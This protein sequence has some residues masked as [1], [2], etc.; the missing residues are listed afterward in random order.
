SYSLDGGVSWSSIVTVNDTPLSDTDFVEVAYDPIK[1]NV[2]VAWLDDQDNGAGV[3]DNNN[4]VQLAG[5][6]SIG[7]QASATFRNGGAN[8]AS[9]TASGPII[10]GNFAGALDVGSTGHSLGVIVGYATPFTFTFS[11]RTLLV[12]IADPGGELLAL[13][14]SP[15]PIANFLLVVP[16]DPCFAGLTV[17]SQGIHV[18]GPPY[19]LSNAQ[20]LVVGAF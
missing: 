11:G 2:V 15:G 9:Y 13:P 10:G 20:D 19:L 18:G 7:G 3:F 12:N 16:N 5:G 17:S 14:L 4:N 1:K 6:Y 8:P